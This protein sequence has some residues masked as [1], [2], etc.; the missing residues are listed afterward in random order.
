MKGRTELGTWHSA[1]EKCLLVPS[2][3]LSRRHHGVAGRAGE[4]LCK[5]QSA[6]EREA[7]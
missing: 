7:S 3:I 2:V 1:A 6:Y 4:V 5:L